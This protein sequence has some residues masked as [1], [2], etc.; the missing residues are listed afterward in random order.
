MSMKMERKRGVC[1]AGRTL[2]NLNI[3][4]ANQDQE[5]GSPQIRKEE[6]EKNKKKEKL[7]TRKERE[8]LGTLAIPSMD[9]SQ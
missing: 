4:T 1:L 8:S 7:W 6:G 2:G 3:E 5:P 9:N